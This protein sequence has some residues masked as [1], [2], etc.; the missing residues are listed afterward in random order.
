[1][2]KTDLLQNQEDALRSVFYELG[3]LLAKSFS[4]LPVPVA[5]SIMTVSLPGRALAKVNSQLLSLQ[6]K[7]KVI[8]LKSHFPFGGSDF[9]S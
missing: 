9:T 7:L 4:Y 3:A 6:E 2:S 1:V 8:V 5:D